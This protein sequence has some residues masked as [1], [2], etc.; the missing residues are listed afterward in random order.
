MEHN[1]YANYFSLIFMAN[2]RFLFDLPD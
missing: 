2:M 1:Y